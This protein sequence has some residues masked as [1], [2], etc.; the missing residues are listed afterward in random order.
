MQRACVFK[1]LRVELYGVRGAEHACAA[2]GVFFGGL[3]VGGG[4][5]AEKEFVR[6]FACYRGNQRLAMAFALDNWQAV[7]MRAHA[8]YQQV[9]AVIH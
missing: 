9:V 5:G 2:A 8:A 6:L 4:V 7:K 3:G 1:N